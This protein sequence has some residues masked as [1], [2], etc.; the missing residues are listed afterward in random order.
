MSA[1]EQLRVIVNSLSP[2]STHRA[3]E[4]PVQIVLKGLNLWC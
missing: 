4:S 2:V 1:S 3:R